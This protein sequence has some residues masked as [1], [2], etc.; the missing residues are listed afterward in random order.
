MRSAEVSL[1]HG[2]RFE[3]R[4]NKSLY[5]KRRFVNK[6]GLFFAISA[7]AFGLFWLTWI[8][9]T[10]FIEGFQALLD[11]PVFLADTPPP[12]TDR[13]RTIPRGLGWTDSQAPGALRR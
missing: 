8:L 6:L 5:N 3:D 4:Y 13:T 9:V 11:M 7:M 1:N 2:A 12:Q 10:L